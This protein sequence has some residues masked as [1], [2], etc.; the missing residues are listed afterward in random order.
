MRSERTVYIGNIPF[1][2]TENDLRRIVGDIGQIRMVKLFEKRGFAFIEMA[3][4]EQAQ[5][6]I[7][8]VKD[9]APVFSDKVDAYGHYMERQL[10]VGFAKPRKPKRP[11]LMHTIPSKCGYVKRARWVQRK[12][13]ELQDDSFPF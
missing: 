2:Y 5:E 8:F 3:T 4:R 9:M 6:L 10:K 13:R 1:S 11:H 12:T 7:D